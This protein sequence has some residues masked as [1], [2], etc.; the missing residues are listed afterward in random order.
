MNYDS[1]F[2]GVVHD[3]TT[4]GGFVGEYRWLS[5]F[6]PC[7]VSW[8][9]LTYASSEAAYQSAKFFPDERKIF[10][11]LNAH[12]SKMLAHAR[13][14]SPAARGIWEHRRERVMREVVWAKFSQNPDL[15]QRLAA[16]GSRLLEET[17]WWGDRFFGVCGGDGLNVLGDILM[18]TR[19]RLSHAP[20]LIPFQPPSRQVAHPDI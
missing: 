11:Q 9:G 14:F 16:T 2:P 10:T 17:N 13:T 6:F 15:A 20:S 7:K 4:I 18:E 5:N 3:E 1:H 12:E 8:E 19:T